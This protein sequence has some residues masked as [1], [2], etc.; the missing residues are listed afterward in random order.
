[1]MVEPS[2][3]F[4]GSVSVKHAKYIHM[5]CRALYKLA[6]KSTKATPTFDFTSLSYLLKRVASKQ[7]Y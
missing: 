1:M 2:N 7:S 4:L 3:L 6:K 5:C